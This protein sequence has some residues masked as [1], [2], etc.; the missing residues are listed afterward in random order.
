ML[1]VLEAQEQNVLE[2]LNFNGWFRLHGPL[3]R[4]VQD[5]AGTLLYEV[6]EEHQM[7]M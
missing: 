4:T 3:H 2:K 5:A 1:L 6:R 7:P